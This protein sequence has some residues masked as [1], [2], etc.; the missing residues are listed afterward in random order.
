M[1]TS[2]GAKKDSYLMRVN[3]REK[4]RAVE[5]EDA[6]EEEE[7]KKLARWRAAT[8]LWSELIYSRVSLFARLY[9]MKEADELEVE[10]KRQEETQRQR[11]KK[12]S[13]VI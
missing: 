11:K 6:E 12:K 13:L 5:D 2:T 3:E 4:E 7:E 10:R 1:P 8:G 9:L